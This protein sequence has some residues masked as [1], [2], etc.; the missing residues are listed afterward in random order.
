MSKLVQLPTLVKKVFLMLENNSFQYAVLRNYE[1]LPNTNRSRDI[2]ILI[3]SEDYPKIR[4]MM[5]DLFVQESYSIVSFFESERLRTFICGKVCNTEYVEII[6]FDFFVHTSVYGNVIL[7][8][9]EMLSTKEL[10]N[11]IY[12]VSKAY[13]FL[14]KYLYLKFIGTEYPSK[15][16]AL[17][18]EVCNSNEVADILSNLGISSFVEL[19]GMSTYDFRKRI[20]HCGKGSL[21][22]VLIFWKCYMSNIIRYKGYSIGFTGPDGSGKTTVINMLCDILT[23]VY[24]NIDLHHFRPTL[25]G[26]LGD[27]AYNAKLKKNVDTEYNKPHRGKRVGIFSSCLRLLYYSTDYILGYFIRVRSILQKRSLVIFDRYYTDII[28][29]NR[30][31]RIYLNYRFLYWFGKLFIPSLNYN[32]LLTANIDTILSRKQELDKDS[33]RD[34]NNRIDYLSTKKGYYKILNELTPQDAVREILHIVF[35]QQN[36]KNLKRLK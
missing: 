22:N 24:S 4:I 23:K 27:I 33:I 15:Y 13:Q 35:E 17:K 29:D 19:E 32:I 9:E 6:Q 2:D 10:T 12:H 5:R 25:F 18:E 26:N 11:G 20:K 34:I 36:R 16:N 7:T 14:D 21:S 8:A 31:S 1:G 28:C 30:R 3:K